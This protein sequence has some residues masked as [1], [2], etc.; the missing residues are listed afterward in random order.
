M[1]GRLIIR[2][3]DATSFGQPPQCKNFYEFRSI[4]PMAIPNPLAVCLVTVGTAEYSGFGALDER[5]HHQPCGVL[6]FECAGLAAAS[7]DYSQ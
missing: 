1:S 7:N 3:N 6:V 4:I 5:Q 2:G